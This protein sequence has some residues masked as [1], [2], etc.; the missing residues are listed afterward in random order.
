M[1]H[2]LRL[3]CI[4][5]WQHSHHRTQ[6]TRFSHF[7]KKLS[8]TKDVSQQ[9]QPAY[10]YFSCMDEARA[11]STSMRT[12]RLSGMSRIFTYILPFFLT[13]KVYFRSTVKCLVECRYTRGGPK[14]VNSR[15]HHRKLHSQLIPRNR[16]TPHYD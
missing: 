1:E 4:Y 12:N 3:M 6:L 5:W 16:F 2:S 14:V 15:W 7:Q 8:G 13:F 9:S 10:V 11:S